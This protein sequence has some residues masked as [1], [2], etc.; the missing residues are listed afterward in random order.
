[1]D[2]FCNDDNM[3]DTAVQV[4]TLKVVRLFSYVVMYL[5]YS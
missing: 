1:M 4:L 2:I 3:S 5:L